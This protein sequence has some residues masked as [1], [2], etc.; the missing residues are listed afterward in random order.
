MPARQAG[1]ERWA[2]IAHASQIPQVDSPR[3][4]CVEHGCQSLHYVCTDETRR[5]LVATWH[6]LTP[7]VR[8]TIVVLAWRG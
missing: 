1:A 8:T 4:T 2:G 5:E 3:Y 7:S 6:H